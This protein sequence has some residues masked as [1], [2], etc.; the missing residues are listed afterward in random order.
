M[1]S[2]KG[3]AV[4]VLDKSEYEERLNDAISSGPYS[5]N[6]NRRRQNNN[7]ATK[8]NKQIYERQKFS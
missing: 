1:K 4:V 6:L 8:F 2:D 3:N 5:L 7:S